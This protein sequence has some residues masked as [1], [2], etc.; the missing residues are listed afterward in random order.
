MWDGT[1][2]MWV[3]QSPC[4][5]GFLPDIWMSDCFLCGC[6]SAEPLTEASIVFFGNMPTTSQL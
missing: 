6:G 5:F 1:A 3:K 2:E 4:L